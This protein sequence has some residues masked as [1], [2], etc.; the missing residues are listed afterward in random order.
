MQTWLLEPGVYRLIT[1][2]DSNDDG[3]IDA[4]RTERTLV[5]K[6]RVNQIQL[7]VP[8]KKLQAVVIEQLKAG[9]KTEQA[10]D[11]ALS[12]RDISV[13]NNAVT[14]KIHNVGNVKAR[15]IRVELWNG[16]EMTGMHTIAEIEAPNDLNPRF[17][18]IS[19]NL[20]EGKT[21]AEL[22]VKLFTE[23]PEITTLNNTASYHLNR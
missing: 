8:S 21:T 23:Q 17:K 20:P 9:P 12:S 2:I 19:F 4:D 11:P 15:N 18:T 7:Q 10:A 3:E 14:V 13:S 6:E 5:L 22:T 1:G 16:K